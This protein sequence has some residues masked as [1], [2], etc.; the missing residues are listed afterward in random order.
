MLDPHADPRF[1][2]AGEHDNVAGFHG[3]FSNIE[4]GPDLLLLYDDDT[5]NNLTWMASTR[6]G[7]TAGVPEL[8]AVNL[9]R[10]SSSSWTRFKSRGGGRYL[11][12]VMHVH[13]DRPL[14]F[15]SRSRDDFGRE[16]KD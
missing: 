5:L 2:C 9:D 4:V 15:S 14:S 12:G 6:S 13:E 7:N 11:T 1:P 16:A 3:P 10:P 8:I